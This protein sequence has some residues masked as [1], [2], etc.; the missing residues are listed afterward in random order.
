MTVD[1][2]G[3]EHLFTENEVDSFETQMDTKCSTIEDAL[4][5]LQIDNSEIESND[6]YGCNTIEKHLTKQ[7][8]D[9]NQNCVVSKSINRIHSNV[10]NF[11]SR[12]PSKIIFS[13]I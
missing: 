6:V 4:E 3:G 11:A 7:T 1:N 9:E 12:I 13:L 2:C 10:G 8:I 5:N